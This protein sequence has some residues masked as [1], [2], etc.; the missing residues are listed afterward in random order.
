MT[1]T[2]PNRLHQQQQRI[3]SVQVYTVGES[4]SRVYGPALWDVSQ[5]SPGVDLATV[6]F[7]TEQS[8]A[9]SPDG[10]TCDRWSLVYTMVQVGGAWRI[11]SSC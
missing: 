10:Q 6:T 4:S 9:D 11:D 7:D 3:G 8:P 2:R 1:N 5:Q